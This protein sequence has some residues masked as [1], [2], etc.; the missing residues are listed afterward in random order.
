MFEFANFAS[1][2]ASENATDAKVIHIG[3]NHY[4]N[5]NVRLMIDA[6]RGLYQGGTGMSTDAKGTN[7]THNMTSIQTRLHLKW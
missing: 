5:S 3:L 7:V 4:F 6:A 2:E 1:D